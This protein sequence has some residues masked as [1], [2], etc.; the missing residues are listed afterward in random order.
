MKVIDLSHIMT[1]GMPVY[2]GTKK[3]D[4]KAINTHEKNGFCEHQLIISSHTGTHIDAPAHMIKGGATLD[5]MDVGIF[6]GSGIVI[7]LT[8]KDA[9]DRDI[10]I[11]SLAAYEENICANDFILLNTGWYKHWGTQKY[12]SN[13]PALTTEAARWLADFDLKGIGVDVISIDPSGTKGF[14]AHKILL[15]K[16]ILIIENLTDLHRITASE[17]FFS[18]LP[19]K[20]LDAD[21]SPVRAVAMYPCDT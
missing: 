15:E 11:D 8:D 18:C 14:P 2:P 12:F 10:T 7:D 9:S 17:I 5:K 16:N 3:P 13:Y 1:E 21:G 19:I 6:C 4:I 20:F